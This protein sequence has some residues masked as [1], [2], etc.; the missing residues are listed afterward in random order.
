MEGKNPVQQLQEKSGK[1]EFL[2]VGIGASA[3]G[4]QALQEF[5]RHGL[6]SDPAP[7]AGS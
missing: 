4:I 5:F 6:R 3:G 7:F 1:N 2:I